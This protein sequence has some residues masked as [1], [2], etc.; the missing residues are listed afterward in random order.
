MHRAP[1]AT[2]AYRHRDGNR[3]AGAARGFPV[4]THRS[5][6]RRAV[7]RGGRAVCNGMAH[8]TRGRGYRPSN[9]PLSR[10]RGRGRG[11]RNASTVARQCASHTTRYHRE[12]L[13]AQ[14]DTTPAGRRATLPAHCTCNAAY[15]ERRQRA[16]RACRP[17]RKARG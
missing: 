16:K 12:R 7:S 13:S 5:A 1:C 3:P 11:C 15:P 8:G 14:R 9:S 10:G 6:A 4:P 2:P 17:P